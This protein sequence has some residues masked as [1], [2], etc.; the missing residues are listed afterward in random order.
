[1]VI[2]HLIEELIKNLSSTKQIIHEEQIRKPLTLKKSII[3]LKK[4]VMSKKSH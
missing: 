2:L 1:M 4:K 3:L